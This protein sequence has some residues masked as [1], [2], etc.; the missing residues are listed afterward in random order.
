M[1]ADATP[2]AMPD[3]TILEIAAPA[4]APRVQ[5]GDDLASQV[6][7]A[8]EGLRWADGS[9]GLADGDVVVVTSKV[10]SKAEGRIIAATS[11]E[12]AIDAESVRIVASRTTPR[13]VTRIVETSHGLVMAAAGVDASNVEEGRVVLLPADPDASARALAIA[14]RA[15]TGARVAVVVTDTMGRPWRMG[16]TD[17]A[18]GSA[19]LTVLDDHTGRV[20]SF[21]RTLEMT[22]VAIADEIAA[23]ADLVKSKLGDRPVAVV[24]GM[25]PWVTDDLESGCRAVIRPIEEDLFRLGTRE[26]MLEAPA[27]RRTVRAF[28][29]EPVDPALLRSA[30]Q[31]AITAPAP[32]GTTPWR[33]VVLEPGA[34]RERLLAAMAERWRTDLQG[35][36]LESDAIEARL[37]RGR[38]LHAAPVVVLPFVDLSAAHAYPDAR[39]SAAERE[40]FLVS[41]G[42][43]V[44]N[45]MISLAA[46]GAGSAWIGS[47]MFCPDVVQETLR[48]DEHLAPLG[49]IAVGMP[50]HPRRPREPRDVEGFLLPAR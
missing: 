15:R 5:P 48:L 23:A 30:L 37:A 32:H 27:H 28:L 12:A 17:V 44:Q 4:F 3:A 6:H 39:R 2:D 38:L 11:R 43:A 8:I 21:G 10:V 20:D 47:T 50:A 31:A 41:G 14:L 24:R 7:A 22:V 33:F 18:I 26:A 16:V 29:D 19:G 42:A 36:G 35:D 1:S 46:S 40:M 13:G 9:S 34:A 45:L 25:G 49:A